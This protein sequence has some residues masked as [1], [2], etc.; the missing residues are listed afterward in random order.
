MRQPP[1]AYAP[2]GPGEARVAAVLRCPWSWPEV[3]NRS[4]TPYLV[5]DGEGL[6]WQMRWSTAVRGSGSCRWGG[7]AVQCRASLAA[8]RAPRIHVRSLTALGDSPPRAPSVSLSRARTSATPR[9]PSVNPAARPA[10][11]SESR[12]LGFIIHLPGLGVHSFF[13]LSAAPIHPSAVAATVRSRSTSPRP[14]V[15]VA[16]RPRTD[17]GTGREGGR[18]GVPVAGAMGARTYVARLG[19][20]HAPMPNAHDHK[21]K[22]ITAPHEKAPLFF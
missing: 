22:E 18:T 20:S 3:R 12:G 11:E 8:P 17:D 5:E 1:P 2:G 10:A 21:A 16:G 4:S 14:T 9:H 6:G 19:H 7:G 15:P 13:R